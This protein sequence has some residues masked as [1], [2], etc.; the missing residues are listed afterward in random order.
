MKKVYYQPHQARVIGGVFFIF[1]GMILPLISIAARDEGEPF[2][3][4]LAFAIPTKPGADAFMWING[5]FLTMV[6]LLIIALGIWLITVKKRRLLLK[7]GDEELTYLDTQIKIRDMRYR[8]S[9]FSFLF[10]NSRYETVSYCQIASVLLKEIPGSGGYQ[11]IWLILDG[12]KKVKIP[13]P[14]DKRQQIAEYIR[15]QI[16]K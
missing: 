8:N 3:K 14:L 12:G 16:D 9:L 13:A 1:T 11:D 7:L 15:E 6:F 5:I 10:G 2:W 4:C